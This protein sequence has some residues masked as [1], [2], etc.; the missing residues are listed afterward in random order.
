MTNTLDAFCLRHG[1]VV[2]AERMGSD[3]PPD[4][5][6]EYLLSC[7]D[8]YCVSLVRKDSND[9]IELDY[10]TTRQQKE[11]GE[12]PSTDDILNAFGLDLV[13]PVERDQLAEEMSFATPEQ[14]DRLAETCNKLHAFFKPDEIDELLSLIEAI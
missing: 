12:S 14:I 2:H 8:R 5:P 3:P 4:S 11:K 1:I 10:W 6:P 9:C 7:G 13:L